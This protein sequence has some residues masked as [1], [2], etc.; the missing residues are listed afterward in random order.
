MPMATACMI[1]QAMLGNGGSDWYG[2]DYY[3]NS[4]LRNPQ[5][6]STGEWRVLRGGSWDYGTSNLRV[7]DRN[8]D[9]PTV[10]GSNI[11]FR[12]VAGVE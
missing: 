12:C 2:E 6:S 11:G 1:W 8:Y 7:A 9:S 10:T 4:P 3:S 5:G